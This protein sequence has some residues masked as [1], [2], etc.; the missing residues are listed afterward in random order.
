MRTLRLL[1]GALWWG[2]PL[3]A[4]PAQKRLDQTD[5]PE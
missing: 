5:T 1:F 3:M 4:E 2:C